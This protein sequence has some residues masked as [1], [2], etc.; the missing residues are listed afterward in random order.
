MTSK[1]KQSSAF[2]G[3]NNLDLNSQNTFITNKRK[4]S[5][6]PNEPQK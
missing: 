3:D 6:D 4:K 1:K 2:D 5:K